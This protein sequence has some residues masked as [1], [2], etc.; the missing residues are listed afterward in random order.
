MKL[1]LSDDILRTLTGLVSIAAVA[2]SL[3][4]GSSPITFALALLL[5]FFLPG[6]ALTR[7]F[8]GRDLKLDMFILISIGTSLLATILIA[9]ALALT[10]RLTTESALASLLTLTLGALIFDR[11]RHPQN[12]KIEV[13]IVRPKKEDIDPIVGTALA[14]GIIVAAAFAYLIITA[15]HPSRT[16]IILMSTDDDDNLP[17][18]GTVGELIDFRLELM[19]GDG[20]IADFRVEIFVGESQSEFYVDDVLQNEFMTTLENMEKE[21][22]NLSVSPTVPG[23]QQIMVKV[24]I[25]GEYYNEVHFW[26]S[27]VT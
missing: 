7:L 15:E 23:D 21:A 18:N 5:L 22:F 20:Q 17:W 12:R 27:V 25:D 19:N 3:F 8:F 4:L 24:Y 10:V 14:F 9:F 16:H 1:K 11:L 2:S 26:V 6:Y 13:E